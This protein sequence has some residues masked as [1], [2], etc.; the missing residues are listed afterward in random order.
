VP[1]APAGVE[2]VCEFGSTV[3]RVGAEILV[4]LVQRLVFGV[5]GSALVGV[6][7]EEDDADG[8]GGR[9]GGGKEGKEV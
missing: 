9:G 4:H 2:E 1:A 5:G 8:V 3:L 6:G 7:A